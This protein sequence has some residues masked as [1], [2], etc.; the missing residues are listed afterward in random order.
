MVSFDAIKPILEATDTVAIEGAEDSDTYDGE[1]F[2][3]LF[4][5]VIA[6]HITSCATWTVTDAETYPTLD[7]NGY[8]F[9][10]TATGSTVDQETFFDRYRSL[11]D[12]PGAAWNGDD[13]YVPV[14]S[15]PSTYEITGQ[16]PSDP[17]VLLTDPVYAELQESFGFDRT[18]DG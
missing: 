2:V 9:E 6:S 17:S 3:Q 18:A 15:D 14:N 4:E 12:V 16:S 1:R 7:G 10:V 11:D 8:R 5:T 13:V